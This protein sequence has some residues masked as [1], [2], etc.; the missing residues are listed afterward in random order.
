MQ[1]IF[2]RSLLLVLLCIEILVI[3]FNFDSQALVETKNNLLGFIGYVGEFIRFSFAVVGGFI[4]F[5]W[6]RLKGIL[7]TLDEYSTHPSW[8]NWL[9]SHFISV[10][11]F[12]YITSVLFEG[13]SFENTHDS[14]TVS[15]IAL[16]WILSGIG[17]VVFLFFAITPLNC[18]SRLIKQEKGLV[19]LSFSAGALA[20]IAGELTELSWQPLTEL[21]FSLSYHLLNMFYPEVIVEPINKL[22]GTP[23]F[24]VEIS[25]QC[26]GYEGI[27]LIVV[28]LSLYMVAFR[29]FLRFPHVYILFPIGITTIWILNTFRIVVLIAIGSSYSSEI[30]AGGFHSNAGWVVFVLISAGLVLLCQQMPYFNVDRENSPP[31]ET[32]SSLVSALLLPFVILLTTIILSSIFTTGFNWFYPL[33]VITVG[34]VL[35]YFRNQYQQIFKNITFNSLLT[36]FIVFVIWL[37]FVDVSENDNQIFIASLSEVSP[38][39]ASYWFL[40]RFVG[41]TIT[42]PIV[43]ELVFRGYLIKKLT[44]TNFVDLKSI[45]FTWFSFFVSSILFGVLHGEWIAGTVA[46][47]GFALALYRRG[48]VSDA[49]IA[50]MTT[51]T[52]LA[53][54][55]MITGNWSLW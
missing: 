50:H 28:F 23:A 38:F 41:A 18:W 22:L 21:T 20:W 11:L 30:A 9:F 51:N 27:G 47:M 33:R 25:P 17:T 4:I 1:S 12:I 34:M 44:D 14:I 26:S 45:N 16:S 37:V 42:V 46:G 7:L 2:S 36:G 15:L 19:F 8:Q 32:N 24:Q 13:I 31:I 49:I 35:W 29:K 53:F 10:T 5:G 55:I 40:F 48:E 52:L 3:S 39:M 43:E 54:Y 6:S